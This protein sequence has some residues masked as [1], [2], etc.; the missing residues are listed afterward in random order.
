MVNVRATYKFGLGENVPEISK[1]FLVAKNADLIDALKE[2]AHVP[3]IWS[4]A[5]LHESY[6]LM[7]FSIVDN[8]HENKVK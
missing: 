6:D 4:G 8:S 7:V 3:K 2:W 5:E 1:N